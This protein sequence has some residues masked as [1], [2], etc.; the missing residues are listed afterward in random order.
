[1]VNFVL[2]ETP[3]G[4]ALFERLQSEE[5]GVKLEQ[6]QKSVEDLVKFGKTIKLKAIA[7]FKNA[8][9]AL[10]NANDISEGVVNDY[11]KEFLTS[12]LSQPGLK[13]NSIILGI[14]DK[15]LAGSIKTELGYNCDYG[16][17]VIEL[18]RGIRLHSDKML[19]QL[20]K[21]NDLEK[22]Q[23]GLGHSYSRAKVKFNVN[24]ADNMIIQA[25][26]LLDQLDKDVNTFA[27]RVREWYSWHFPELVK[28]VNDNYQYAKLAKFI[29]NK[30]ELTEEQLDGLIEITGDESK[31]K[32]ILD[33]A[34]SSMG[35]D[36]SELDMIN[37]VRFTDRVI[38]LANYRKRMHEYLLS[39]MH[40]VAPNLSALIG[41]IV[42]ARLISHAGSLT[43]LS[44]Y[45]ASTVQILGAEKAL[46]RALKTKGNTPKYGL[47]YH[48]SFIGRA[49]T[50]NKGRISR[51]LANKC[52]IASRID[53]FSDKPSSVFG[54][55][56]KNQVEERL[57][58]YEHGTA[59]TKNIDVITKAIQELD[60]MDVDEEDEENDNDK[61]AEIVLGKRKASPE[62]EGVSPKR[63]KDLGSD[64]A[65][66]E[67]E[68]EN[69]E[70]KKSTKKKK[71]KKSKKSN[72]EKT[73]EIALK[74]AESEKETKNDDSKSE[75]KE[76][77][78]LVVPSE[79]E[80]SK[81]KDKKE[82]N[83]I[84]DTPKSDKKEKKGEEPLTQETPKSDKK[85]KKKDKKEEVTISETPKSD[86]KK[87]E[88][89]K[90][91]PK[92]DKKKQDST[93]TSKLDKKKKKKHI[94]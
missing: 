31:A 30:S 88:K 78:V 44:K 38:E 4:Y 90:E 92:S 15:S 32:Q 5:I 71:K 9:H 22:G 25:I 11:L 82:A 55:A 70:S 21:D 34:K 13:K 19:S 40:N 48:S 64:D 68:D 45:P 10:E 46:F 86:K 23:L 85:K 57:N 42:G 84:P 35:T 93:E 62:S 76:K 50:K 43:N 91:T 63:H 52:T 54:E 72:T 67:D 24:R 33:A 59:V 56:L 7:P 41:E 65:M 87:D 47:L 27:M 60:A 73:Q 18:L 80:S 61:K 12:N 74:T 75:E 94:G 6:V 28:I 37:I 51:F 89:N 1:M 69:A 66:D 49:G 26:S 77:Y 36:I 3:F 79:L 14:A 81:K 8:A 16:E 2:F 58:F 39:K 83:T 17:L 53:C 29:K 20:I